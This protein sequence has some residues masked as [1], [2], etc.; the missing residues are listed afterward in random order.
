MLRIAICDDEIRTCSQLED[1]VL[2]FAKGR[3]LQT[4]AEVFYSGEALYQAIRE[5]CPFDL[6]LLDI[7]MLALDGVELGRRIREQLLNEKVAIVYISSWALWILE[8]I[9]VCLFPGGRGPEA[10]LCDFFF[11]LVGMPLLLLLSFGFPGSLWRR[12][13]VAGERATGNER[14]DSILNY[15]IARGKNAGNRIPLLSA[16]GRWS[17]LVYLLHQP[18][19]MALCRIFL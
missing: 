9:L 6:I 15:M 4:E 14:I 2:G 11:W 3:G 17:I 1:M 10:M 7:E 18:V 5:Q 16:L 12:L 8:S 19:C 13:L